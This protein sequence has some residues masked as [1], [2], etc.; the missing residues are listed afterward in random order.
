M[1]LLV[2]H[3]GFPGQFKHLIRALQARGDEVWT[4][5]TPRKRE[6]IPQDVYYLPY[7]IKRGNGKDT[8]PLAAELETKVIRGE[9]VARIAAKLAEGT[10][11]GKS[12]IPDLIVGH[13]GWGEMLFLGDVWPQTKQLHYVEFFHGIKGTDNDICDD[14]A[15]VQN[16]G[17]KARAR[18]KNTN[19]LSNLNQMQRGI[20]P[21]LFQHSLLPEWAKNRTEIIHDGIDTDWL[22]PDSS[23]MLK[24]PRRSELPRG[25]LLRKG[26]PVI[27]FVN[28]TF[29]PYRGIHIF[30]KALAKL[31][32]NHPTAQTILVGADTP[33]VSYGAHRTDN[34]GWL[35]AL[36]DEMGNQL[37]WKRIHPLGQVPHTVL[38]DV[39]RISAAHVYLSYPFVLSW[40]MLE[41]MSCSVPIIASDTQPVTEVLTDGE[42]GI[43][44]DFFDFD[45]ISHQVSRILNDNKLN[46][47]IGENARA[48]IVEHYDLETKSMPAQQNWILN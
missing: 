28:R 38:R 14:Y 31:Q 26:D 35:T 21:T 22:S 12:W 29:E 24:I 7:K 18:I 43:L 11:T 9:A 6:Q 4:I 41:A 40:S 10:I 13:P 33:K 42:N 45:A 47:Y 16:W 17:E 2:I 39:Y 48:T 1:K 25:L 8:F 3:N 44:V 5:G 34:R 15:S 36:R 32:A 30:L 27:T 20:C 23:A 37:D 19:L 46:R